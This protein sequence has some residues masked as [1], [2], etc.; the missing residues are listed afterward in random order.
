ML[1]A[2]VLAVLL[3][4]ALPASSADVRAGAPQNPKAAAEAARIRQKIERIPPQT[5]LRVRFRDG[6]EM[7]GRL[8][9]YSEHDFRLQSAD[10]V[11]I[12]YPDVKS[13]KAINLDG[14]RSWVI[15]ALVIPGLVVGGI[16]AIGIWAASQTR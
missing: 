8:L 5:Y 9:A 7:R 6:R 12:P 10:T 13:V 4:P 2:V 14:E 1:V 3:A 16:L 15:R 11:D